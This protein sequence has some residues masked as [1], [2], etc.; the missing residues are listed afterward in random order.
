[1]STPQSGILP[2]ASSHGLFLLFR[3]RLGRRADAEL[4]AFFAKLPH[5][6]DELA[7]ANP[8]AKFYAVVG[9]GAEVWPEFYAGE[10]PTLL[11]SFPRIP[12]AIHPAPATSADVIL[13]LRAERY[14]LL[15]EF[16]DQIVQA[17]SH[18][19]D[20]IETTHGFRYRDCRDLTGFVDGTE[21]PEDED[22]A[23]VALV[24]NED[25]TWAGGSYLH[26][27]RYVHRMEIWNKLPVKQQEAVIG[28]T[29]ESNEELSDE[30]KPL[31]AHI[32]RVVIEENEQELEIL[33]QSLPY[34]TPGGDQ[35]LYFTSYCK[36]PVNFEK[37]LAKMI[38]PTSDGRVDHLL[39]FSRAVSGAA[40]FVPSREALARLAK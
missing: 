19:L 36:T 22:R 40:F 1:M 10:K 11:R 30:D 17:S 33:R 23:K 4:K 32:S 18:C 13:H 14:D 7:T 6:A 35:G 5:K 8:D 31:T 21:N 15:H 20:V 12:G 26:V 16:A 38:S 2:A 39:N 37:M 29:K 25:A 28:R 34:G 24:G 27:Q 9:F 3:R